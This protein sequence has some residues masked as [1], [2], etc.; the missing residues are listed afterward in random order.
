MSERLEKWCW[1][2]RPPR[3]WWGPRGWNWLHRL[4]RQYPERPS[5]GFQRLTL[6]RLWNFVVNLPCAEC[7]WHASQ[8]M[9]QSPPALKSSGPFQIWAWLFHNTVN[10]RLG[11]PFFPWAS[12]LALY[13]RDPSP[14]TEAICER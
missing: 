3:R 9:L 6:L 2:P 7:R 14:G 12:Y 4:A 8:Y 1:P 10:L 11:K 13:G 5:R